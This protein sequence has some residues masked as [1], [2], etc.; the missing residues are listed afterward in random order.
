MDLFGTCQEYEESSS[1]SE[2]PLYPLYDLDED[3]LA[4]EPLPLDELQF[5]SSDFELLGDLT[6]LLD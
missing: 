3:V 6:S 4:L 1:A 5:D 2:A